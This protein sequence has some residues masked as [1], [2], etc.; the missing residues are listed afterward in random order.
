MM[1]NQE[2]SQS[3]HNLM[4]RMCRMDGTQA[5]CSRAYQD[6]AGLMN[7]YSQEDLVVDDAKTHSTTE[8]EAFA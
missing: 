6:G 2:A 7:Y 4:L 3:R 5:R 1:S 8:I